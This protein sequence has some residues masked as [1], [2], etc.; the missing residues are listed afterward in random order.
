MF[1]TSSRPRATASTQNMQ[2]NAMVTV[3][4][5]LAT[6]N[7]SLRTFPETS[8]PLIQAFN[9]SKK[10]FNEIHISPKG[11]TGRFTLCPVIFS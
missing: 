8:L 2:N 1:G 10:N 9:W 5:S 6:R 3:Q 7:K 11:W 4:F